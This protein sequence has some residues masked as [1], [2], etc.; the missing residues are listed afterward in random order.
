MLAKW[1]AE[2]AATLDLGDRRR[3]ERLK[4]I[5]HQ[6]DQVAPS[7]PAACGNLATLT[8]TYR[9]F[10]NAMVT[11]ES[12]LQMHNDASIRRTAEHEVVVLAQ[13]TT[14]CDLT[15][16]SRQVR[17]AGPLEDSQK[18]GFFLHPLYA[19]SLEGLALG[20]VDQLMWARDS[21]RQNVGKAERDRQI[22]AMPF[23]EKESAR[24][25]EMMQQGEQ[26]AL[27]NPGT[28][29]IGVSDSESDIYELLVENNDLAANYDFVI[30]GCQDRRVYFGSHDQPQV[31][32]E[33][34]A[35]VPYTHHFEV[36]VSP[37]KSLISGE[38]RKRRSNREGRTASISVRATTVQ[39]HGPQRPGGS[40]PRV[41]LQVVEAVEQDPPP[42]CDPI[43]W[44][45]FTSLPVASLTDIELVL[46]SYCRRW[47]IELFFK[48]LKSG[49]GI[50]KLKYQSL[51]AYLN[52]V[53]TLMITAFRVEQLK[54]VSRVA[55]HASCETIYDD[56]FWK[57]VLTVAGGGRAI[58]SQ[59]PS[60]SDLCLIIAKLGGYVDQPG[61]GPP[62]STT[63]W[64]GLLKAHAYHEAYLAIKRSD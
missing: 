38:T 48:T 16:P 3:N 24:W 27:A 46:S 41:E 55:P 12:I 56:T 21:I 32:S 10:N 1:I 14:V 9:L 28:H 45:L 44:V 36:S 17:G 63:I 47:D 54:S 8:A 37:R 26:I 49:M 4:R 62:G 22:K 23:E 58:D 2:E 15:K 11:P 25:L 57:A 7:T 61:Q 5:L 40:V 13:D 52:A 51:D 20:C 64:R 19:V 18:R 29:Y 34:I 6:Y 59:P 39:L 43:H 31:L 30:R 53:A 35:E 50:E 60:V 33:A 42:G